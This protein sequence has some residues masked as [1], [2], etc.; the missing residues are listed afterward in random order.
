MKDGS[1][2]TGGK[3]QAAIQGLISQAIWDGLPRETIAAILAAQAEV[4]KHR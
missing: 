2:S 4:Q 3:F 1:M